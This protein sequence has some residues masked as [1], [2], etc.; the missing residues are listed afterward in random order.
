MMMMIMLT[1]W[2]FDDNDDDDDYGCGMVENKREQ[3]ISLLISP[4]TLHFNLLFS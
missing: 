1:I 2:Y 3:M 4:D